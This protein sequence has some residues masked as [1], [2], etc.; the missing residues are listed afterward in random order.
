MNQIPANLNRN[1]P[2]AFVEA[3][4]AI[5]V[6]WANPAQ[7]QQRQDESKRVRVDSFWLDRTEVTI[8]E[9]R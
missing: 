6:M 1:A 4:L 5:G 2:A 9:L 3:L 7:A 8:G